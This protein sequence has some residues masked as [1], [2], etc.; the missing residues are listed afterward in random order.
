M[1]VVGWQ[2]DKAKKELGSRFD[3]IHQTEQ[4]GTGHAVQSARSGLEHKAEHLIVL[5]GDMPFIGHQRLRSWRGCI[6][7][8][9][10]RSRWRRAA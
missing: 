10:F 3:Y 6:S 9:K 5:Y 2:A 7:K 1:I 4:L 8:H